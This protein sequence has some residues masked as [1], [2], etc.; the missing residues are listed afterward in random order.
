MEYHVTQTSTRVI[1]SSRLLL[2]KLSQ[3]LA[4]LKSDFLG[5]IATPIYAWLSSRVAFELLEYTKYTVDDHERH[6][7]TKTTEHQTQQG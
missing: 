2:L 5:R 3:V 7:D 6:R 1:G 4:H